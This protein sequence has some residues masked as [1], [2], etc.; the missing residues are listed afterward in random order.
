MIHEVDVNLLECVDI[1]A[2]AH[3][4]NA[5]CTFGSGIALQIKN[6]YPELYAADCQT[7]RGDRNKLGTFSWVKCHDGKIGYNCYSQFYY[8]RDKR[9]TDYNAMCDGLESIRNHALSIGI[10]KIGLPK[11]MGCR[12]GGGSW[13]IVRA[14][15]EDVFANSPIDIYICNYTPPIVS[16]A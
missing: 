7:K 5:H 2:F 14:I 3:Q 15:I 6:K 8:G 10:T 12:L 1:Q 13:T 9:Y 4:S 16:V 11:F